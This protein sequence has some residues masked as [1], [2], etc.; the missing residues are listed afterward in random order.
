M[1][2]A[3]PAAKAPPTIPRALGAPLLQSAWGVSVHDDEPSRAELLEVARPRDP[4]DELRFAAHLLLV[5]P[6]ALGRLGFPRA[7]RLDVE[8]V[9]GVERQLHPLHSRQ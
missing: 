6:V 2:V 5:V 8:V 4:V 9:A 3:E 1:G 7:V